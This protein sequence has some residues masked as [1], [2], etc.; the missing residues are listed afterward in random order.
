MSDAQFE[1]EKEHVDEHMDE[2]VA[3]ICREEKRFKI[4]GYVQAKGRRTADIGDIE[5]RC[6]AVKEFDVL[7][8]QLKLTMLEL[9]E[10]QILNGHD[11]SQKTLEDL[12]KNQEPESAA[13]DT[14]EDNS[15]MQEAF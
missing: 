6:N 5:L 8:L 11:S 9:A 13:A 12:A 4:L 3:D 1:R 15:W 7:M 10:P 2:A 14:Y